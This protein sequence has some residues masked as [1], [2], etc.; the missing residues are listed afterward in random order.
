MNKEEMAKILLE[1]KAITLNVKEPYTFTAGA[2]SPIYTDNRLLAAFPKERKIIVDAYISILKNL[3]YDTLAGTA[4]AGIQWSAWIAD[5]LEKPMAYVRGGK[6]AH[7]LGNQIEGA[8]VNNKKVVVIEDLVSTGG[9]S[10]AAV[11][12]CREA[13]A[14][15][16]AMVA[17]FTY[18]YKEAKNKFDNANCNAIFLTDFTTLTNVAAENNFIDKNQLK[19]V[20]EWNKD[21]EAWGPKHGFPLGKKKKKLLGDR[22][23]QLKQ[24]YIETIY[25]TKALLIKEEQFD[26]KSGGKSHIY[27]N[28]RNFLSNYKY[29]ELIAKIYLEL[30][31]EKV[32]DYKLCSIDSVMSPIIVG[33]M[34]A[35]DN[36]DIVV[37]K[38][39]K[40]EHGTKQDIYGGASGE[41]VIVDDM[42]STGSMIIR[43][44]KKIRE[45]KGIVRYAVVSSC[46]DKTAKENLKKEG[47]ELLNI[48]SFK[49]I[50]GLLEPHL[51]DKEKEIVEKE[52]SE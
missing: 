4:T 51:T 36:K 40:L 33:A 18:E 39:K 21:P 16:V 6:K 1:K 8:K 41:I 30:L 17:I 49:E 47:I 2:R 23:E 34:C 20:Q 43:A 3:N 35:L 45:N 15:V 5:R 27:L 14:E 44:A 26:L 42:T 29:L 48:A 24:Q 31:K 7:G 22:I 46:R 11:E 28:H 13:G 10:L 50:I 9:S 32:K 38:E 19:M 25:K 12:A 37:V 52:Y